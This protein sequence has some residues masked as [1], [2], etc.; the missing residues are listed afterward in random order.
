MVEERLADLDLGP[1]IALLESILVRRRSRNAPLPRS[2]MA[3]ARRILAGQGV[4]RLELEAND[5]GI[6]L[7]QLQRRFLRATGLSAKTLAVI[8]RFEAARRVLGSNPSLDVVD[9]GY[10]LGYSDYSHFSRDFTRFLGVTPR[11]FQRWV[12]AVPLGDAIIM[13]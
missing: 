10:R 3:L 13:I 1:A 6:S 2:E 9:L 11:A 4:L 7:R 8:S 5:R 12:V